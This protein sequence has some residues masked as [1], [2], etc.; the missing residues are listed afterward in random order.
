MRRPLKILM[1]ALLHLLIGQFVVLLRRQKDQSSNV[2]Q[3]VERSFNFELLAAGIRQNCRFTRPGV[4]VADHRQAE[5]FVKDQFDALVAVL[6][7]VNGWIADF[8]G[9]EAT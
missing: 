1:N 4:L 7:L 3:L 8:P 2:H 9:L 5:Q 6:H